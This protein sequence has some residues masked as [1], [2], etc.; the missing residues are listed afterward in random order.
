MPR[1]VAVTAIWLPSLVLLALSTACGSPTS[2]TVTDSV[3]AG[4]WVTT[5]WYGQSLP[6][7][8]TC[9]EASN[10]INNPGTVWTDTVTDY[11]IVISASRSFTVSVAQAH[12]RSDLPDAVDIAGG[13]YSIEGNTN[14]VS[15]NATHSM[16][17][18]GGAAGK[19]FPF[20]LTFSDG[21]LIGNLQN[22]RCSSEGSPPLGGGQNA[23]AI[24]TKK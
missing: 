7:A 18:V 10:V 21:H 16:S 6:V 19:P 5:S 1:N 12:R 3:L 11:R 13:A 2:S 14:I 20:Q 17:A 15:F 4:T 24:L 9:I 22:P 8:V 23:P